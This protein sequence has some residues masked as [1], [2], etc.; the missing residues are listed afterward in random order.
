MKKSIVIIFFL[1]FLF[2]SFKI[3]KENFSSSQEYRN[4]GFVTAES[5]LLCREKPNGKVIHKFSYG[6]EVKIIK[7]TN[8]E[9]TITDNGKEISGNWV[10]VKIE[11]TRKTGYVFDGFLTSNTHF[12]LDVE[13]I[14]KLT[15]A[16]FVK[17]DN[18]KGLILSGVHNIYDRRLNV[19]NQI[20][21]NSIS[22]IEILGFT[23][24]ERP[25]LRDKAKRKE[26]QEYCKWANFVRVKYKNKDFILFGDKVLQI[27]NKDSYQFNDKKINFIIAKSF[28]KKT[29]TL[30]EE[31]S[32]CSYSNDFLIE[33]DKNYSRVY[34]YK[35]KKRNYL[36]FAE[37]EGGY[38]ELSDIIVKKDTI[39]SKVKQGFQEGIGEYKVKVFTDNGWKFIAYDTK[40]DYEGRW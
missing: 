6:T 36:S 16:Q 15:P 24:F 7:T 3:K 14:A 10:E 23:M 20:N 17:V 18:K 27:E 11:N 34:D 2:S 39:F 25:K 19:I 5:G 22:E 35:S 32:G 40:R 9:L 29:G 13:K 8:Q 33:S 30:T 12:D 21:I 4:T 28:L 38:E 1:P 26:W 31:L 37:N